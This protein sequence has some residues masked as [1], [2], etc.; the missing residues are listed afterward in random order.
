[1]P[2]PT[3]DSPSTSSSALTSRSDQ[4]SRS[5]PPE[6]T[7]LDIP[8][9]AIDDVHDSNTTSTA[10]TASESDQATSHEPVNDGGEGNSNL[11]QYPCSP[12]P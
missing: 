1:M 3:S 12:Q 4:S 2:R 9:V 6:H 7:D 10:E 8:T 5:S 11:E